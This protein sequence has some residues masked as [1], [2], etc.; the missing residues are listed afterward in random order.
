MRHGQFAHGYAREE[1]RLVGQIA[2]V[3]GLVDERVGDHAVCV[4]ADG[5]L[6]V[7]LVC[8][9][10]PRE[11]EGG[12]YVFRAHEEGIVIRIGVFGEGVEGK[13][14]AGFVPHGWG[15]ERFE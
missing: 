12:G 7:V 13:M 10:D 3:V 5:G 14:Q 9:E 6:D 1:K 11:G 8:C 15:F 2:D 4:G